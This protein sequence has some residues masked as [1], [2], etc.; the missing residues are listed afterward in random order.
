MRSISM[1]WRSQIETF[2][3]HGMCF[4]WRPELMA[5]HVI[6]DALIALAYFSI[7]FA[8]LRFVRGRSDLEPR[9]RR[10]ALLFAAF[11]AFCGLTHLLSIYVL[12]VP[13]YITEGWLKAA[14]AI[15]SVATAIRLN[16]LV[17]AV[18]KLPSAEAMR[19]EIAAHRGTMIALEE[20][21]AALAAKVDRSQ[22]A[23]RASESKFGSVV[24][25]M[26]EGL[27]IFDED[28]AVNF[29]NSAS[30]RIHG[31]E[32]EADGL[33]RREDMPVQWRAWNREGLLLPFE[34]W[35][36]AQVLR[37]ERVQNQHLHFERTDT[38]LTIDAV[39]NG[40][41]IY[42][43]GGDFLLGFITVRDVRDEVHAQQAR[44]AL[45]V[46][47]DQTESELRIAEQHRHQSKALLATV[48][49]AMPGL[50]YAKDRSGRMLLANKVTLESIGRDWS[51]VE[52]KRDD[53][54]LDD[55]AQA[56]IVM[57]NDRKVMET[58]ITQE[59]EEIVEFPTSG[60]R[61]FLSTK[62][63][64]DTVDGEVGGMVGVSIDIT[65][66]KRLAR[67]LLHVSRRSAMGEMATAIAH[68]INQPLASI[69]LFIDGSLALLGADYDGPL[70]QPLTLAKAQSLR[71]G[72]IIRRLRSFVSGGEDTKRPER[73]SVIVDE[74]CSLALLGARESGVTAEIVNNDPNLEVF[75]DSV[76]IEQVV[77]N[78]V[79][80]ALD[81]M[82]GAHGAT[83]RIET[84]RGAGGMAMLSVSDN[85]P[86]ISAA[87][88]G[89][90][91]EAFISTKGVKGMGIGLSICRTIIEN[92]GG[93]I[94][95]DPDATTGATFHL[96]LPLVDQAAAP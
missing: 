95:A 42:G 40:S 46:R 45:A 90:V 24:E 55:L 73:L 43:P 14:T 23:L 78:L 44:E 87:I 22:E 28:G 60:S 17:P 33:Y 79:R 63:P 9:H 10:M 64:F 2:M 65:E 69:T 57:T 37:G 36:I 34:D 54:F 76:Q 89:R 96:T 1:M 31:I 61:I 18:L 5:L 66:R 49:E 6:S 4:L 52:C 3:P 70:I 38:G 84:G 72:E 29:H 8:I 93:K 91:F 81:A 75:V 71:A 82:G 16:M 58:G 80:N 27:I 32:S 48:I 30:A 50:I 74:A 67:E 12:W 85:G 15:V 86:G 59:V 21:R 13:V 56:E 53:E 7:P 26:S 77:V 41:P 62:V 68:E 47:V 35:P 25:H 88:A 51:Q 19:A 39:Y 83:L 94:W 92:H 20:A 11:I